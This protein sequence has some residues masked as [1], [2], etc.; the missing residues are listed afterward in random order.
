M[1][2]VKGYFR[3]NVRSQGQHVGIGELPTSGSDVA[4]RLL[5]TL[6]SMSVNMNHRRGIDRPSNHTVLS[7]RPFAMHNVRSEILIIIIIYIYIYIYIYIFSFLLFNL[8]FSLQIEIEFDLN[9]FK[10]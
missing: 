7:E 1:T 10:Y 8:N 2:S 5:P 9:S 4:N 3:H 6:S